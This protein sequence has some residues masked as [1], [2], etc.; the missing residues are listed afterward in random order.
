MRMQG[1][2]FE[3]NMIFAQE[4]Q[5]FYQGKKLFYILILSSNK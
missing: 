3:E 4:K 2:E 1:L 5:T